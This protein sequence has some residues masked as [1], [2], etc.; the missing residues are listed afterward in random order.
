MNSKPFLVA[1]LSLV[2]AACG[3]SAPERAYVKT[4]GAS[5]AGKPA[6]GKAAKA[7]MA[8]EKKD[9]PEAG[10]AATAAPG[11]PKLAPAGSARVADVLAT[12]PLVKKDTIPN[13]KARYY[14]YLMSAGWC[15]PC[16]QEMPH[17]VEAYAEM[18]RMGVAELILIDFDDSP[19]NARAY[20]DKYAATF[21]AIMQNKAPEL[22]G[23]QPPGGIPSAI[24]VDAMGN[25]VASGHGS[26]T[27]QWKERIREYEEQNKLRSS[28]PR[29]SKAKA[30]AADKKKSNSN[31]RSTRRQRKELD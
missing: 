25:M 29:T 11:K 20:M 10:E 14:V 30:D 28:L 3:L 24:I 19:E 23:I 17:I 5:V 18:K 1:L 21:P 6:A 8:R 15:G 12:L 31:R 2:T 27:M 26:I 22:P 4:P 13:L 7:K 16:N 9:K